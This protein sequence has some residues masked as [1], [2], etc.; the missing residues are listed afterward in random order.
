[1]LK[2]TNHG[3]DNLGQI[4]TLVQVR[5]AAFPDHLLCARHYE[6]V[7]GTWQESLPWPR[8]HFLLVVSKDTP[9]M[10][11]P[12]FQNADAMGSLGVTATIIVVIIQQDKQDHSQ[13]EDLS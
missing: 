4:S 9:L 5:Q 2:Q 1:M 11:L 7:W 10:L 12:S 13:V 8:V 6:G 3:E